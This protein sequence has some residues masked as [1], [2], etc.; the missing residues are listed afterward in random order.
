[1]ARR[2]WA[3]EGG[4]GSP[5]WALRSMPAAATEACQ[6][7]PQQGRGGGVVFFAGSKGGGGGRKQRVGGAPAVV[8]MNQE[9]VRRI[10]TNRQG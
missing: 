10:E 5:S 6:S 1:M 9:G 7:Q 8:R 4:A 3:G 2:R